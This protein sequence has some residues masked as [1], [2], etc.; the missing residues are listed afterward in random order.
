MVEG[1]TVPV[2][3]AEVDE[4]CQQYRLIG[5]EPPHSCRACSCRY[6]AMVI[7]HYVG[8]YAIDVRCS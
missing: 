2:H 7:T 5:G 8:E 3:N 4:L 1:H 6:H